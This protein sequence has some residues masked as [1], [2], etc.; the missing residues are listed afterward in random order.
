MLF[1]VQTRTER[2]QFPR[3][4]KYMIDQFAQTYYMW[5]LEQALKEFDSGFPMLSSVRSS[6][7]FRFLEFAGKLGKDEQK[8]LS[9]ALVKRFHVRAGELGLF[10]ISESEKRLLQAFEM[11]GYK[12][13]ESGKVAMLPFASERERRTKLLLESNNDARPDRK[14]VKKVVKQR[15]SGRDHAMTDKAGELILHTEAGE[16]T[17]RTLIDFGHTWGPTISYGHSLRHSSGL[18]LQ[19]E[20]HICG[21]MG[22]AGM[23][24]WDLYT[25]GETD[26][27]AESI[28]RLVDWFL[29]RWRELCV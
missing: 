29:I 20:I 27:V 12:T 18:I 28:V 5:S 4:N 8:A 16:W 22:I 14:E 7:V 3:F 9:I 10:S 11:Q 25:R 19:P 23:T 21:W 17:L 24:Q 1:L 26:V 13:N 6:H 15:L 2:I